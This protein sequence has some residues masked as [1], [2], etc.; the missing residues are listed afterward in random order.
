MDREARHPNLDEIGAF[1]AAFLAVL[2]A[3]YLAGGFAFQRAAERE[4]EACVAFAEKLQDDRAKEARHDRCEDE[5]RA[6]PRFW[7]ASNPRGRN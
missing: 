6:A 5:F 7:A 1:V 3:A 4:L 2:I